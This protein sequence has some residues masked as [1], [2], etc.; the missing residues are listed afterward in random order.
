MSFVGF[1]TAETSGI[2]GEVFKQTRLGNMRPVDRDTFI[3]IHVSEHPEQHTPVYIPSLDPGLAEYCKRRETSTRS[4]DSHA[5]LAKYIR[6]AQQYLLHNE[7]TQRTLLWAKDVLSAANLTKNVSMVDRQLE[8]F[9][10]ETPRD[11]LLL[12]METL[13]LDSY[14]KSVDSHR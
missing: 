2:M 4:P 13:K 3:A 7:T 14:T 11:D 9:G 6:L 1:T 5:M 10:N 12:A 8:K